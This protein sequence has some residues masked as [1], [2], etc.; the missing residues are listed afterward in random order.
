MGL[1]DGLADKVSCYPGIHA[2]YTL[3]SLKGGYARFTG[4]GSTG[5][6]YYRGV[7]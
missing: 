3:N 5:V 1:C 2:S 6:I 7:L 4:L